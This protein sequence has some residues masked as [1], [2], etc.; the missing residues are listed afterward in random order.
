MFDLHPDRYPVPA[1]HPVD[2]QHG[3]YRYMPYETE[4]IVRSLG[5]CRKCIDWCRRGKLVVRGENRWRCSRCGLSWD[6]EG[7]ATGRSHRS[8]SGLILVE[9]LLYDGRVDRCYASG[10]GISA[11]DRS[12]AAASS[13]IW[14]MGW[15]GVAAISFPPGDAVGGG[16]LW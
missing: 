1:V 11:L 13:A 8:R 12:A 4:R 15:E 9:V 7:I 3:G 2:A 16:G 5:G 6:R 10:Y 14:A